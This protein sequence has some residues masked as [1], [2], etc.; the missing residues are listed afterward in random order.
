MSAGRQPE[1]AGLS[2]RRLFEL[3]AASVGVTALLAACGS[4]EAPAPGRVGNAPDVTELPDEEVND[5]VYLRTLT[6]LE[7]S[8]AEVYTTLADLDGVDDGVV[9]LLGRFTDDHRRRRMASPS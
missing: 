2:R 1:S 8:I 7:Y 3:S 4:D 5:V 6:S 9:E